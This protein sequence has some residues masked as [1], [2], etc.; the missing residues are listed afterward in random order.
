MQPRWH[1][2]LDLFPVLRFLYCTIFQMKPLCAASHIICSE[3]ASWIR[4]VSLQPISVDSKYRQSK[5]KPTE[6]KQSHNIS[7]IYN[8]FELQKS[9]WIEF[10]QTH[11]FVSVICLL[12]HDA[13]EQSS[14]FSF[15]LGHKSQSRW[16]Y[17]LDLLVSL[18]NNSRK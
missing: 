8:F 11:F 3:P 16:R 1:R 6:D 5:P 9:N 2:L 13:F 17:V 7:H 10:K 4:W 15:V 18:E 12:H 14:F